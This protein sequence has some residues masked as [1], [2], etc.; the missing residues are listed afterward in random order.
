MFCPNSVWNT[1]L[2][3]VH[4]NFSKKNHILD[5]KVNLKV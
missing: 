1:C 3:W 2:S 4:G 5:H